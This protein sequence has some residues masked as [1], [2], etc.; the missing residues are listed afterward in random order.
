MAQNQKHIGYNCVF[1]NIKHTLFHK[2]YI[3]FN[4]SQDKIHLNKK[5]YKHYYLRK[6][7]RNICY[8]FQHFY[9]QHNYQHIFKVILSHQYSS[10]QVKL[11][12]RNFQLSRNHLHNLHSIHNFH[13]L[14]SYL[15]IL[16]TQKFNSWHNNFKD[17]TLNIR[18]QPSKVLEDN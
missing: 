11:H 16:N 3:S 14:Y 12:D 7:L 6:D 2:V 8:R 10:L 1:I 17:K 18:N 15:N 9:K 5:C 4:Y 13:K